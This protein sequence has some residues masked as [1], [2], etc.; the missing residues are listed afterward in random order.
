MDGTG[1]IK[2]HEIGWLVVMSLY[3]TERNTFP[4]FLYPSTLRGKK[5]KIVFS[6][7]QRK[8]NGQGQKAFFSFFREAARAK[9]NFFFFLQNILER[10]VFLSRCQKN[11]G[12]K[13][14]RG[15]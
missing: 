6:W 3:T 14:I 5:R 15:D 12:A 8:I 9:K 1:H 10:S 13:N 4:S 7:E 11:N 2:H